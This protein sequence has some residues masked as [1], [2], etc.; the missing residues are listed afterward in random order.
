MMA[1]PGHMKSL[2]IIPLVT[3]AAI[4]VVAVGLLCAGVRFNPGEPIAAGIMAAAAGMLAVVPIIWGR[5]GD[6][7]FAFQLALAGTVLQM[8]AAVAMSVTL[9]ATNMITHDHSLGYW[10]VGGYWISLFVTIGQ[11]RRLVL[12]APVAK[13][14]K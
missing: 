3:S 14:E 7:A 13:A 8:F 2:L 1:N 10:L 4:A 5:P 9:I 6:Q 12:A 11:L